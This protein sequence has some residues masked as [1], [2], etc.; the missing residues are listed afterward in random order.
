MIIP[1][2][3][4]SHLENQHG[5]DGK[6]KQEYCELCSGFRVQ[7]ASPDTAM[8]RKL[9]DYAM[10]RARRELSDRGAV[11]AFFVWKRENTALQ[12]YAIP[13]EHAEI[14]N[15]GDGK[16]L[17]FG[18]IRQWVQKVKPQVDLLVKYMIDHESRI[19][20]LEERVK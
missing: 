20:K 9:V 5:P 17:L 7:E 1:A 6:C 19:S 10:S 11:T 15:S 14:M 4:C 13:K 8:M 12:Y 3:E 2:C 18:V 16:D